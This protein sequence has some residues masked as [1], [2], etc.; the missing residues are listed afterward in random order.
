MWQYKLHVENGEIHDGNTEEISEALN[1]LGK[2][3]WELV[4]VIPQI[5]S[6]TDYATGDVDIDISCCSEVFVS[7][8]VFVF[9]KKI[10]TTAE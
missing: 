6:D 4:S 9:K 1:E 8:N 7:Q 3:G 2:D 5:S 10:E